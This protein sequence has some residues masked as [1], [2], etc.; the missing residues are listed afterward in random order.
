MRLLFTL[1]ILS[2]FPSVRVWVGKTVCEMEIE[3]KG[4]NK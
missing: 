4:K 1:H 2:V 3:G